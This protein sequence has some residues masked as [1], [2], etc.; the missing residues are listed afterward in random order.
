LAKAGES[1]SQLLD[2]YSENE[3]KIRLGFLSHAFYLPLICAILGQEEIKCK[4]ICTKA[5]TL[6]SD[7]E[8][9]Y[10]TNFYLALAHL[11][12]KDTSNA[13]S[14]AKSALLA[15]TVWAKGLL[16][17]IICIS[18]NN[19]SGIPSAWK[20]AFEDFHQEAETENKSMPESTLFFDG[21]ALL[22][23]NELINGAIFIPEIKDEKA[24]MTYIYDTTS[25]A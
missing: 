12:I 4:E 7:T 21:L 15:E 9:V 16:D 8:D 17:L 2:L 5:I 11:S 25:Q 13:I 20:V 23:L 14:H 6:L 1:Y 22:K 18:E 10:F 24:P 3:V 19:Q